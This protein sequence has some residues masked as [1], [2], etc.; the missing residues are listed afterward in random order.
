MPP[1]LYIWIVAATL[2]SAGTEFYPLVQDGESVS[3]IVLAPEPTLQ[4]ALGAAELQRYV[5]LMTGAELTIHRGGAFADNSDDV[6]VAIGRP[7]THP[8]LKELQS[9]GAISVDAEDLTEEGFILKTARWRDHDVIAISGAGDVSTLY[10]VYD[11][12]ERFGR[13]G[14]F[15]YEEHVPRNPDFILP[16][17]DIREKPHFRVRMHGGQ[18]HYFGIQWFSEMQWKENLHWYAKHRLNRTNFHP[19]PA[20]QNQA[21]RKIWTR[22][23]VRDEMEEEPLDDDTAS[24]VR[25]LQR[26]SRYGR[27]VG[28]R[29]PL[30]STDGQLPADVVQ[31]FKEK[32]PDVKTFEFARHDS[33]TWVDP[34]DPM[35]LK[36]NQAYFETSVEFY[37]DTKL[38]GLPSP[39]TERA[40]GDSPEEQERLTRSYGD[41][42]GRLAAWAEENYPGGEWMLDGW[43][44]A[45]RNF[46][47]PDRVEH[48][49]SSLPENLDLVIWSYPADDQPT[50]EYFNFWR[51][52]SWAF[53]VMHS[54]GG[55]TTVHGDVHRIMGRTY[56][57]LCEQ[58]ADKLVGYGM[59]TEAND[60]APFFGDLVLHLSWD[61]F[62]DLDSFTRDYCERRYEPESVETMVRVHDK[63]LKTVYGPQSDHAMTGGFRTVRLHDPV[64]W[65]QIGG[66]W[67][68]FDELQRRRVELRR[69]WPGILRKALEEALEVSQAEKNN[70]AYVRDLTDIM[71]AYIHVTMDQGVWDAVDAAYNRDISAFETHVASIDRQFDALLRAIS[72]VSDRWEYG[73]NA[74]IEEF[75]DAPVKRSDEEI[76]HYLYY[77]SFSGNAIYDYFR[78]DRY[79]M[80]RDIYRP[81]TMAYFDSC[82]K[83]LDGSGELKVQDRTSTGWEYETLMDARQIPNLAYETAGPVHEIPRKWIKEDTTPPPPV[84][85]L[86]QTVNEFLN[87]AG[88][89]FNLPH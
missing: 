3:T 19:G 20:V 78:A 56:R 1:P 15:R 81:M 50:Y 17:C 70:K 60:Y 6:L 24:A 59:Y 44:F 35:W 21:D 48:L 61:P 11:F 36:L 30:A 29:A 62:I 22:L 12:L 40:P 8:L 25:M 86:I 74:M 43:A 57:A 32:F 31:E 47:H 85:D 7:A 69:H 23:G 68:P 75:A 41:A 34:D 4:E 71:R 42:V 64:Y 89:N 77:V 84:P 39:W 83:Q 72:L 33:Q 14:F 87:A 73:V 28:V 54:S 45:N 37:G 38:Y 16:A 55:N 63:L 2:S 26:M 82:R 80:I 52:V 27:Q 49:L 88:N 13:I 10:A 65:Y 58:R 53:L 9:Q 76:R 46:W 67:V 18:Y 79:E 51:P 66:P 5:R